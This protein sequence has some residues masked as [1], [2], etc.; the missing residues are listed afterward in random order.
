[1]N[2]NK[3]T[4]GRAG[5]LNTGYHKTVHPFRNFHVI[6]PPSPYTKLQLEKKILETWVQRCLWGEGRG[7]VCV[8]WK[9]PQKFKSIPRLLSMIVVC[10][11]P[12]Y[13]AQF[14]CQ[15]LVN[16]NQ[17]S[18]K[19]SPGA[20]TPKRPKV[21]MNYGK[22]RARRREGVGDKAQEVCHR[23]GKV[24]GATN[25]VS[26]LCFNEETNIQHQKR[27]FFAKLKSICTTSSHA[28]PQMRGNLNVRVPLAQGAFVRDG[29]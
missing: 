7:R 3:K 2:Y 6:L 11:H 4:E 17:D 18:N 5:C 10:L 8:N 24:G 22:R 14:S 1:M 9:T 20:P 21:G 29:C 26:G 19:F 28:D 16:R 15:E 13:Y 23:C 12:C 25:Y 27:P